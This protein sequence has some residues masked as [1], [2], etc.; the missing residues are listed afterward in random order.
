MIVIAMGQREPLQELSVVATQLGVTESASSVRKTPSFIL[1]RTSAVHR[2]ALERLAS[3][4]TAG[5][6][7]R[8]E[9]NSSTLSA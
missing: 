6:K 1:W 8:A 2:G 3:G 4:Q 7:N 9:E 5:P